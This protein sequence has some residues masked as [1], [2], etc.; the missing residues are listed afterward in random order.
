V[1]GVG[2]GI[3]AR[4]LALELGRVAGNG[5]TAPSGSSDVPGTTHT[6]GTV[7]ASA[8]AAPTGGAIISGTVASVTAGTGVAVRAPAVGA[9]RSSAQQERR[10][11]HQAYS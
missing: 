2:L 10:C 4:V 8:T 5:T 1:F 9:A 11:R 7:V 3:D 6:T